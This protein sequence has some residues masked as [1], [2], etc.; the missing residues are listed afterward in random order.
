MHEGSQHRTTP[1]M[2]HAAHIGLCRCYC[3]FNFNVCLILFSVRFYC[4]FDFNVCLI[5]MSV[6]FYCLFDF[7]V[8]LILLSVQFQCLFDFNVCSILLSVQFY[9]LFYFNICL[10]LLSVQFQCLFDFIVCTV[11]HLSYQS[12]FL[13][14]LFKSGV[15]EYLRFLLLSVCHFE[16]YMTWERFY[17]LLMAWYRTWC[18][19]VLFSHQEVRL[20]TSAS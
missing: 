14:M 11:H 17:Q 3:L 5:L 1:Q 4:R 8:C 2:Q 19:F 16:L 15:L 7:N 10:I 18:T 9:C 13:Y 6:W 20:I 12:P